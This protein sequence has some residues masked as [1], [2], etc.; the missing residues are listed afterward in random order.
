MREKDMRRIVAAKVM[1]DIRK[2]RLA[3]KTETLMSKT[4]DDLFEQVKMQMVMRIYGVSSEGAKEIIAGR[5]AEMTALEA[6]NEAKQ[7]QGIGHFHC[8]VRDDDDDE[9]MRSGDCFSDA[10]E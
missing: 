1:R 3:K 6:E 7:E 4:S 5:V 10:K 8:R 2:R 9:W